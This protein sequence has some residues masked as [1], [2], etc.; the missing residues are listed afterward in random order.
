M[1]SMKGNID[2]FGVC[3]SVISVVS[4][5]ED[6]GVG[7]G[8]RRLWVKNVH[9]VMV[10]GEVSRVRDFLTVYFWNYFKR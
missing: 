8:T 7:A 1:K 10:H 2:Y 4:I 6:D 5:K 3:Y 9:D